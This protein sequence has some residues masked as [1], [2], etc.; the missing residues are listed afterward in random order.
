[1]NFVL[2]NGGAADDAVVN[3]RCAILSNLKAVMFVM[4]NGRR[5]IRAK[6]ERN[7]AQVR[8]ASTFAE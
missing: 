8:G 4:R 5:Y 7:V 3:D 1:M 2:T 6:L